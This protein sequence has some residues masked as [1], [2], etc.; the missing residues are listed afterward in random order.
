VSRQRRTSPAPYAGTPREEIPTDHPEYARRTIDELKRYWSMARLEDESF[1]KVLAEVQEARIW[2]RWPPGKAY[3]SLDK[4]CEAELG[5]N[6]KGVRQALA[7]ARALT[8]KRLADAG[9]PEKGNNIT[10][11]ARRGTDPDYLVARL[12]R[13]Y[14]DYL[15]RLQQGQFPS[16]RAAARAAGIPIK[17]RIQV[18]ATVDALERAIRRCLSTAQIAELVERLNHGTVE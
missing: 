16:V 7:Q 2:K 12:A 8:P 13:D 6:V 17:D 9:R 3:G 11:S 4:L 14:P 10:F 5:Q 15:R 18:E 1:S